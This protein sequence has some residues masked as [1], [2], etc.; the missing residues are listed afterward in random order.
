[1]TNESLQL[2]IIKDKKPTN[3]KHH[4]MGWFCPVLPNCLSHLAPMIWTCVS[5]IAPTTQGC[6][7]TGM[8]SVLFHC[9]WRTSRGNRE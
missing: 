8:K 3:V 9:N 4:T 1:M 7:A 6:P 5:S 2:Y